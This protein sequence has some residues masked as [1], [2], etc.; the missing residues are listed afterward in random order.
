MWAT[1][2]ARPINGVMVSDYLP[3]G[4]GRAGKLE[5]LVSP[6]S[7]AGVVGDLSV[8]ADDVTIAELARFLPVDDLQRLQEEF[9]RQ[10]AELRTI[11]A[12]DQTYFRVAR[13]LAENDRFDLFFF[14]QRGPDMISHKFWRYFEPDKSPTVPSERE[15]AAFGQLVPRYYE[16]ADEL[17]GEVLSW[18]PPDRQVAV[19][20]DHGFFGPRK[21]KGGFA[22]GTQEHSQ[23]GI[24]LVRSPWYEAGV[25]FD[26][27]ELYD[28]CPTFLSLL[29]LP[30]SR[31]MPGRILTEGLTTAGRKRAERFEKERVASYQALTPQPADDGQVDPEVDEEIRKQLRSLGYIE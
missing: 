31:E 14:Y 22:L 26:R 30:P 16:Y 5:G 28:L 27:M 24:F 18:F 8:A 7:L 11:Y 2:P 1:Y 15:L 13:W 17:L 25:R 29:G 12:S 6:D 9:P 21:R 10:I 3:Y 19:V 23:W 20:S 4:S